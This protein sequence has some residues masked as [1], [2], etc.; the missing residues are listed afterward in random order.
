MTPLEQANINAIRNSIPLPDGNTI[1]QKVIPK[2]DIKKYL[3]GTYNQISGFVTTAKDAKHLSTFED[4]YYGMRLDYA[5]NNGIK[6]FKL[7]DG[8]FGV[9]RYKTSTTD[10]SVPKLPSVDGKVPYTG[11][12]FTGGSNGKLGVPEWQTPY[13]TPIDGAELWEITSDGTETLRAIFNVNQ[14]KF[15]A[16]P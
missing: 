3:D 6:P 16:V 15:I 12:G 1:L 4:V 11:N 5:L 2:A 14:N 13:N 10:A 8:S 7:S 9:I